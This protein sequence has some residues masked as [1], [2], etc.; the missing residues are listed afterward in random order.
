VDANRFDAITRSLSTALPRRTAVVGLAAGLL[1][2]AAEA[3]VVAGKG[4]KKPK[5]KGERCGKT[6]CPRGG[7]CCDPAKG[8]CCAKG[9]SC[10]NPGEETGTCCSARNRCGKPWGDETAPQECCPPQRQ[11]LTSRNLVRCCPEGTRAIQHF[12]V[13]V[14]P[15]CPEERVCGDTCC[16]ADTPV[17][18][19]PEQGRCCTEQGACDTTCCS[20]LFGDCC[21]G[22]CLFSESGPWHSCGDFC[23]PAGKTCCGTAAIPV[24]CDAETQ[25]CVQNCTGGAPNCCPAANPNCCDT[26]CGNNCGG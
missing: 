13:S 16:A 19:D 24:C 20:G 12:P 6:T 25:V 18:V 23:C 4:K 2:L 15:C 21:E 17:C 26:D 11:F 10:C 1:R 8:R 14:G 7:L 9:E 5:K 3:S 22:K